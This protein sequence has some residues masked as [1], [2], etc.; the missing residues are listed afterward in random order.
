MWNVWSGESFHSTG[1]WYE[2]WKRSLHILPSHKFSSTL[3]KKN[4]KSGT[5]HMRR[6]TLRIF[7]VE[8]FKI[9]EYAWAEKE[10]SGIWG[11]GLGDAGCL[12]KRWKRKMR[13]ISQFSIVRVIQE[14]LNFSSTA[15][16]EAKADHFS[17]GILFGYH[18]LDTARKKESAE[19]V[20][21]KK[22]ATRFKMAA[23]KAAFLIPIFSRKFLILFTQFY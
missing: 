5:R 18:P 4:S 20:R 15:A 8:K 6:K 1:S 16:A 22:K 17:K 10:E 2:G 13:E 12:L 3:T 11:G 23:S 21:V 19:N 9:L 7:Q 14:I